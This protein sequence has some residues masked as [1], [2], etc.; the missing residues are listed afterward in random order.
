MRRK[1][2][3][4]HT[5]ASKGVRLKTGRISSPIS[6]I[7]ALAS[8]KG[9]KPAKDPW[10]PMRNRPL[11]YTTIKSAP[12]S[13]SNFALMPVPAPAPMIAS[14]LLTRAL[15]LARIASRGPGMV[16]GRVGYVVGTLAA[17]PSPPLSVAPSDDAA[18][19]AASFA[20]SRK[21]STAAAEKAG[22]LM[23]AGTRFRRRFGEVTSKRFSSSSNKAARAS[24]SSNGSP[25]VSIAETPASGKSKVK[26]PCALLSFSHM[27][28][29]TRLS[30]SALVR[31]RVTC[32][33][34]TCNLRPLNFSGTVSTLP[35]LT[36]SNAPTETTAGS[37][38]LAKASSL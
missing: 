7:T 24:G 32:A 6:S 25:V 23:A 5:P 38:E 2:S 27:T 8:L 33:L 28:W 36:M 20:I 17:E 18:E 19:S 22:S 13:S 10:P 12:P 9:S 3:V 35:K 30:S 34:C 1:G 11:L 16:G 14:S 37:V 21:A 31:M 4:A 26:G 15:R 29:A